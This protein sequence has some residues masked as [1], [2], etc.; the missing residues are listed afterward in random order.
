MELHLIPHLLNNMYSCYRIYLYF[1]KGCINWAIVLY[2]STLGF[3][4]IETPAFAR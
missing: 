4:F 3:E 2:I 1:S